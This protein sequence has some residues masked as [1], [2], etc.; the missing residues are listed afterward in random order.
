MKK[1]TNLIIIDASGSME[2]KKEAVVSG[3]KELLAQIKIDAV[4][5]K[6]KVKTATIVL[7]FSGQGDVRELVNVGSS[8][9]LNDTVS[10]NYKT[11]G[12]TALYDAIGKGFNMVGA[13]EKNVFVSILTDG[14]ENDSKE[15]KHEDVKAL[16]E[17]KRKL[18]W[19]ITFQGTT[20]EA[21]KS[22][23]SMGIAVTNTASFSNSVVGVRTS[24]MNISNARRMYYSKSMD[25]D[26][27]GASLD[28]LME[29]AAEKTEK[30]LNGGKLAKKEDKQDDKTG[31]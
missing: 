10:A 17:K 6:T 9:T 28:C 4:K 27:A 22:A 3:L 12:M 26:F 30:D 29:Q 18:G 11:R 24:S 1:T 14:Q 19:V 13:K 16:I 15:F 23:V 25:D 31:Q 5:D 8:I 20:E 7:D 21:I 2:S